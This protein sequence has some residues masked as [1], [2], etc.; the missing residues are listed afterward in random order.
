MHV[1]LCVEKEGGKG[2]ETCRFGSAR[3]TSDTN[4]DDEVVPNY[5]TGDKLLFSESVQEREVIAIAN[6]VAVG[7]HY[8]SYFHN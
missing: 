3:E 8:Y 7:L 5:Q 6:T 2:R 1:S 4:N